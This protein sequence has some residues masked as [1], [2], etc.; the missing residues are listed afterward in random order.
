MI[1]A[2][3]GLPGVGKTLI[4]SWLG[5]RAIAGKS[6]NVRG[7]SCGYF[8]TYQRVYTNFPLEG[9]YKLDF[10]ELGYADYNHCLMLIDEIQLFA[11][12]RNF[13]VFGDNLKNFFSQHRKDCI[14]IIWC[15]QSYN[16]ADSRIR[17]L[18]DRLYYLD[19][20]SGFLRVREI[21]AYF[22][23]HGS[24]DEGYEYCS[25]FNTKLFRPKSLYKYCDTNF[26]IKDFV[27]RPAPSELWISNDKAVPLGD[28][29]VDGKAITIHSDDTITEG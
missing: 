2:L 26:K 19:R 27:T 14:D 25:G 6:I 21:C 24:I 29:I 17:A 10:D 3:F 12:C 23:V 28:T 18:T 7:F 22:R 15:S 11:D 5:A 16:N 20:W 1:S 8:D 13:K 4:L 9:A